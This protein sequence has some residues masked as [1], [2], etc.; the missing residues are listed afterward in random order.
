MMPSRRSITAALA[1]AAALLPSAAIAQSAAEI[2]K[3]LE[4]AHAKF[5][6]L[7]EGKNAD[8]I[9]ALAKVPSKLFGIALV[10]PDGKVYTTGD[11]DALFSI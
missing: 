2:D 9:P 6:S 4:D 1:T 11:A 10:T 3:A 7:A 5:T 8:Y